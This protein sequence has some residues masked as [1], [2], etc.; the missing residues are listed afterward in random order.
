MI[1]VPR[2]DYEALKANQKTIVTGTYTLE[3]AQAAVIE[4]QKAMLSKAAGILSWLSM[5]GREK[6]GWDMVQA[7]WP[8]IAEGQ[9]ESMPMLPEGVLDWLGEEAGSG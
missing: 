1:I 5:H 7:G 9:S 2:E 8:V 6:T 3:E 4:R